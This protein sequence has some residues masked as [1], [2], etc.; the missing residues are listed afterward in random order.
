MDYPLKD[1]DEVDNTKDRILLIASRMFAERGYSAVTIR[2]IVESVNIKPASFYNHFESKE[3]LFDAIVDTIKEVYLDFYDRLDAKVEQATCFSDVLDCLFEEL[4]D[5][6]HMFI[7]YGVTLISAEQ[8]R[9][10]KA[11]DTF[12]DVYM[13]VGITYSE[14][15]FNDCIAKKWVAPFDTRALATLFM[16]SVFV[17]SLMR[18]REDLHLKTV[19]DTKDMYVALKELMLRSVDIIE[20]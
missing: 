3:K 10:K 16:N 17:G 8:F 15:A 19:Y 1:I 14:N 18:A 7:H 20:Q 13:N 9:D 6:Y 5:V 2:D 4:L 12:N 11:G